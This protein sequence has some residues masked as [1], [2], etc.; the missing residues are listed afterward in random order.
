MK[1]KH[2]LN[3]DKEER[4]I[5]KSYEEGKIKLHTPTADELR[6]VAKAAEKLKFQTTS[7]DNQKFHA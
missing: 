1:R 6:E 2:I 4:E 3:L 7:V 5:L